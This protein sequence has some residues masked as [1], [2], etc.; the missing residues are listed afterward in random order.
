VAAGAA[1]DPLNPL[2]EAA[3]GALLA[4]DGGPLLVVN[5]WAT[6][7]GPCVAE[8]ADLRAVAAE[9]ADVRFAL[10]NVE[11]PRSRSA[12]LR[13]LTTQGGGLPS[14]QLDVEDAST[15]LR[16]RVPAWPDLIPVTLVVEP[17][18]NLRTR[19]DGALDAAALREA[20]A[21]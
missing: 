17:G 5:F 6:W 18:G 13:F 7:C 9:R 15:V 1:S 10:V 11:G 12:V 16:R 19:F 14:F 4:N 20:L 8:L 21:R 2:D 3:L